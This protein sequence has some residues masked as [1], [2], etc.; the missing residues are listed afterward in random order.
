MDHST[1]GR[2]ETLIPRPCDAMLKLLTFRF[3][4]KPQP[5]PVPKFQQIEPRRPRFVAPLRVTGGALLL[6]Y[7]ACPDR[8]KTIGISPSL[9]QQTLELPA[10]PAPPAVPKMPPPRIIDTRKRKRIYIG[11]RGG[12]YH[13][14]ASG[15]KVYERK[16]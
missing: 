2:H 15:K 9:P 3:R 8:P 14:S 5:L 1:I 16:K 10:A 7:T 4:K 11:P 6:G 13:Y 12:R